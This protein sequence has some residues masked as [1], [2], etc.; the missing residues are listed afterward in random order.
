MHQITHCRGASQTPAS[1]RSEAEEVL[2]PEENLFHINWVKNA[3][4]YHSLSQ[5]HLSLAP[6]IKNDYLPAAR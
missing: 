6:R 4:P 1:L 2:G 3:L 5:V